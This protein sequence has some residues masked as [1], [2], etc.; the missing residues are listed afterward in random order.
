MPA[1]MV[2]LIAMACLIIGGFFGMLV[3]A[4]WQ[5]TEWSGDDEPMGYEAGDLTRE[6]P[7]P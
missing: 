6:E 7:T 5:S 3:L 2:L 1:H 4:L